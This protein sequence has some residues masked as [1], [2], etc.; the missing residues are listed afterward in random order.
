MNSQR[1]GLRNQISHASYQRWASCNVLGFVTRAC[2]T[3]REPSGQ[4]FRDP[5]LE[6]VL[7]AFGNETASETIKIT[8]EPACVGLLLCSSKTLFALTIRLLHIV[9]N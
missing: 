5:C 3:R 1:A 7:Q 6:A 4:L 8:T 9:G 2:M